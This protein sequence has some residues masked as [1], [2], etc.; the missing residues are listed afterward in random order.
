MVSTFSKSH[1][2][3]SSSDLA[4]DFLS[5]VEV[6]FEL[7]GGA[8][9]FRQVWEAAELGVRLQALGCACGSWA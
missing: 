5:V 1:C 8:A 2:C 3:K 9:G 7:S 4:V 6:V